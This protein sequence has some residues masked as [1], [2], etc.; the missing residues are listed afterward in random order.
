MPV[1]RGGRCLKVEI[2]QSFPKG[3]TPRRQKEREDGRGYDHARRDVE[4]VG[5]SA[6]AEVMLNERASTTGGRSLRMLTSC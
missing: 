3:L 5:P 4:A 2:S 6:R 1:P